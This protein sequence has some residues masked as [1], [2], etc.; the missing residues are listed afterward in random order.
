MPGYLFVTD[1]AVTSFNRLDD[2]LDNLPSHLKLNYKSA[3]PE[4]SR[5]KCF[6]LQAKTLHYRPSLRAEAR[7]GVKYPQ[8]AERPNTSKLEQS[9]VNETS[10][11]C[12]SATHTILEKLCEDLQS[13]DGSSSW[14]SVYF[15]F[16][17]ATVFVV[18]TLCPQL[19]VDLDV[20]PA[21][22]SWER[23]I[24]IFEYRKT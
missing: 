11:L 5:G 23:A 7:T 3:T 4:D 18:A 12:V 24:Q 9:I 19:E 22:I 16:A 20:D 6:Q 14:H 10:R 21:K 8:Y 17:A 13:L 2:F 1:G 15:A